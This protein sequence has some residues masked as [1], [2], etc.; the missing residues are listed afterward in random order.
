[1][2]TD[3]EFAQRCA[4]GDRQAWDEFLVTY[5]RLLYSCIFSAA[6]TAG[7]R[8]SPDE[9]EDI[10]QGLFLSLIDDNS[11]K[12][13][14]YRGINGCTLASWL[15]QV[16]INFTLSRMEKRETVVS[17]EEENHLGLSLRELIPDYGRAVH[18]IS[19]EKEHIGRLGECIE[20]LESDDRYFIELNLNFG[21]NLEEI[22]EH[23]KITRGAVDMR[24]AR[25]VERLRDCF[26]GKGVIV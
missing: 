5:S 20:R 17:L 3:L 26:K 12:L 24:K 8:L 25:I 14:T 22:R 7:K 1:M 4:N 21:L 6:R 15:R 23:L 10:F 18:D 2:S 19:S 9:H 11:R 16:A 13:K